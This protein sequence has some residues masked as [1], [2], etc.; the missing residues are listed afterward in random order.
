MF[1]TREKTI[2]NLLFKNQQKFT[3]AQIAAQLKVSSRTVKTDIKRINAELEK[4]SCSIQTKQGVGLWLNCEGDGE[5]FLRTILYGEQDNSYIAQ[6]VRKYYLAVELLLQNRYTSMEAIASKFY[7]SKGTAVNDFREL[8][9]EGFWKKFGLT[10]IKK[11][12]YGI[13]VEGSETQIRLA[14]TDAL[15]R[16]TRRDGRMSGGRIQMVFEHVDLGQIRECIQRTEERFRYVL[17]DVSFDEFLIQLAVMGERLLG[18]CPMEEMEEP[19]EEEERIELVVQYLRNL[20]EKLVEVEV[21]D[22]EKNY[23]KTC[24]QGLRYHVPMI[25]EQE[26]S[27]IRE[28]SPEM[29]DYMIELLQR[30]DER[31]LLE[32]AG[33]DELAYSMFEHLECM[34]YRIRSKMFAANPILDSIKKEMFFEYD[35]ASYLAAKFSRKYKIEVTEEE[36]GYIAFHIGASIERSRQ[37]KRQNYRVTVV[38]MT[39]VGTSQ[40]ISMKLKR[41]FAELEI[42]QIL[43]G[44]QAGMLKPDMQDFVISTVPLEVNVEEIPVIYVSSVLN[45]QD[46][47]KIQEYI[48]QKRGARDGKNISCPH[49]KKYFHKEITILGCD[50]RSREEAIELL[51]G[52][53]QREGYASEGYIAS[54]LEREKLS[55][56]AVGGL[57]AI[58]HAFGDYIR[59]QGIGFMTF[60]KPVTWGSEKVQMVLMLALKANEKNEF[61]EIFGEVLELTRDPKFVEQ[62]LKVKKFSELQAAL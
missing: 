55:E 37:R 34:V 17:T 51:G 10:F 18:G 38:C 56:T 36:I 15:K 28:R 31:Y 5:Q 54:V 23:L 58:P 47:K 4:Y 16:T 14:A 20:L 45:E 61:Q 19:P 40:F 12:K 21:P 62:I 1:S 44:K 27:K 57:I 3:T 24:M 26:R 46:V 30:V 2:L 39:G 48:Q 29:F 42:V 6:D 50:L 59:K 8:E 32:L 7:V 33:D 11:V 60:Q 25:R 43:S 22:S 35:I 53:M 49:L 9:E 41:L 52:R 13:R